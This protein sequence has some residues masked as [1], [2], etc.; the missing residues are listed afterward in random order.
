MS[1]TQAGST[2]GVGIVGLSADGG[3]AAGAHVPALAALEGFEL[4]ALSTSSARSAQA[5]GTQF[6]VT[7]YADARELA[8]DAAVDLVVVAVKVP[9]H[10]EL[11]NAAI[12]AGKSV[13]C[14]WPLAED[15]ARAEGL[16]AAARRADVSTFVGLQARY[17][18]EVRYAADLIAR[19]YVGDV[20]SSTL[21]GSGGT[22]GSEVDSRNAYLLDR[23]NGATLLSIPLGHTLDG[24]ISVLGPLRDLTSTSAT[25]RT[26]VRNSDTGERLVQTTE[27][28]IAFTGRFESGA[29]AA[30]HYRGGVS[31]GTNLLWEINGT[32]GD[33]QIS[34]GLGH[35]QLAGLTLR[36]GRQSDT[37]LEALKVPDEYKVTVGG[38]LSSARS[39]NVAAEYLRIEQDLKTG[40]SVAP[41]FDHG[42]AHHRLLERIIGIR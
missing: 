39:R 25:L 42:L 14:E 32:E 5:A 37:A 19:G 36:G 10:V 33:L 20:L 15:S 27:D 1:S 12:D 21:V 35:M 7:A 22:W 18:P 31:R 2:I 4:R 9:H 38:K 30:V 11:V 41:D 26:D 6:G 40:S 3:W 34:G 28:Q 17:A 8:A 29:V 24:V 16:V 13:L 23:T